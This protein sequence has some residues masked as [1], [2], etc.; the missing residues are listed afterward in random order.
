MKLA[1]LLEKLKAESD[2]D[3]HE[4][5]SLKDGS[6]VLTFSSTLPFPKIE[7]AWYSMVVRS[8]DENIPNEK[9]EAMLRHLWMFQ[10]DI[11]PDDG[12]IKPAASAER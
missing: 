7:P 1:E 9:I 6:R 5:R 10:L 2:I 8:D 12:E 11:I 3:I 4:E